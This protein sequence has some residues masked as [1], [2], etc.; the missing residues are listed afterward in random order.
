M[1][2]HRRR[3][4]GCLSDSRQ[5]ARDW[6][7]FQLRLGY[8]RLQGN[9]GFRLGFEIASGEFFKRRGQPQPLFREFAEEYLEV[10][11]SKKKSRDRIHGIVERFCTIFGERRLSEITTLD[12]ERY[13][14]RRQTDFNL[15]LCDY[16]ILR[17]LK[18]MVVRIV[19][20]VRNAIKSISW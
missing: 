6:P 18:R 12:V 11:A 20:I 3:L 16:P 2:R 5:N 17:F 15:L 10:H 8:R 4:S 13:Q 14:T 9:T 19:R 7:L 1:G